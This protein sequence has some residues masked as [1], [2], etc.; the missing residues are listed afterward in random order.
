[1]IG[2]IGGTGIY[3]PEVFKVTEK[4][5][6]ETPFGTSPELLIGELEK[7]K[8]VFLPRHGKG[9]AF[10]P[11]KVNYR[12]NIY[13][14][15]MLG[16]KRIIS[17]NSV[18]GINEKFSP[19]DIVIPHDFIDFTKHREVT[20]Y[21][22]K[23]VHV[24]VSNPYCPEVREAL[25]KGCDKVV[26]KVFNGSVHTC[27]VYA[28]TEGPR[29][30]TPAEIRTLR[31]L[32]CDIVGMTGLPEAVLARELEVCYASICTVTNYAAGISREKLTATEVKEIIEENQ[33]TLKRII[34]E[35]IK[36]IPKERN[37]ACKDAL[38][39]ARM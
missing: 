8:V 7:R 5:Q 1:M 17:T 2:I 16:V 31:M 4:K 23:V 15:K 38:K 11:H 21:D 20:F 18:G 19:R 29:F 3:D 33:E 35:T 27:S 12:S 26:N 25:I 10:P 24:D 39:G 36:K 34:V 30:E 9:H 6:V 13:A 22:D 37:C 28:C 32:G 14:L